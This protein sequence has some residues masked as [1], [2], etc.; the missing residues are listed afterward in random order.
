MPS[1]AV[2]INQ[3]DSL[4]WEVPDSKMSLLIHLLDVIGH[5]PEGAAVS[6]GDRHQARL[7]LWRK[8]EEWRLATPLSV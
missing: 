4:Y 7:D 2:R 8:A 6:D 1:N 3:S 5:I